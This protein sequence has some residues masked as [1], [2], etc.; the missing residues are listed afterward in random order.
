MWRGD[1]AQR[2]RQAVILFRRA[3]AYNA[4]GQVIGYRRWESMDGKS[5][6]RFSHAG[7]HTAGESI[8]NSQV[9]VEAARYFRYCYT[10]HCPNTTYIFS[11]TI[12]PLA[13]QAT[14]RAQNCSPENPV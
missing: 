1:C 9:F 13:A 12:C 14:Q 3:I 7:V 8:T 10:A 5:T 2:E 11:F 6:N 4:G